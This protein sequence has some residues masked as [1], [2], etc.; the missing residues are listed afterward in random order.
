LEP[1]STPGDRVDAQVAAAVIRA[2]EALELLG[3]PV[4]WTSFPFDYEQFEPP[5]VDLWAVG[6]AGP[7]AAVGERMHRPLTTEFLEPVTLAWLDHCRHLS[8][9]DV[10]HALDEVN[11][12]TRRVGAWFQRFD[13]LL[14]PTLA[15]LPPPFGQI[16]G[17]HPDLG[18]LGNARALLGFNPYCPLFNLTGQPALTLPLG[19]ATNGLPI[20]V[21]LVARHSEEALLLA[22]GAQLETALPWADRRPPIHVASGV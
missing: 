14:T 4:E 19:Q 2:A 3:H 11:R 1:P 15:Q 21:Q 6:V 16:D 7:I 13:V 8:A 18:A 17:N 10:T 12:M 22:L 9:T 5:F 20:G